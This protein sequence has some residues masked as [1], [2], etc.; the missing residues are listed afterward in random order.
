MKALGFCEHQACNR[1][2]QRKLQADSS[3]QHEQDKAGR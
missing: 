1:E 3:P 2:V